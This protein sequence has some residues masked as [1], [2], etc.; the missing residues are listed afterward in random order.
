[1]RTNGYYPEE[2]LE[3]V[4]RFKRQRLI[5]WRTIGLLP[6]R[7]KGQTGGYSFTDLKA[8]KVIVELKNAGIR[9]GA[10]KEAIDAIKKR[11]PYIENPLISKK[12]FVWGKKLYYKEKNRTYDAKTG[13][14]LLFQIGDYERELKSDLRAYLEGGGK[15]KQASK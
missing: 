12:L 2:A 3:K 14:S 4:F 13:Q 7:M 11:H 10:I 8:I 5:Y 1:M 6:R 9:V 15:V